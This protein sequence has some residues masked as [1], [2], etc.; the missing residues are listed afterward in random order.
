MNPSFTNVYSEREKVYGVVEFDTHEDLK[1][2]VRKLDNTE[3][4]NP[5][6]RTYIRVLDDSRGQSRSRSRT[7]SRYFPSLLLPPLS[8][9][10][11]IARNHNMHRTLVS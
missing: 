9:S 11:S 6:D 4:R 5:F 8:L 3:F 1:Y 10:I 2:A 7:R